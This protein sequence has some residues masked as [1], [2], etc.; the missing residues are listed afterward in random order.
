MPPPYPACAWLLQDLNSRLQDASRKGAVRYNQLLKDF[1]H[2]DGFYP[3]PVVK[4]PKRQQRS[5]QS[6]QD[7][8]QPA[9]TWFK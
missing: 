9:G 4:L 8:M 1:Q 6:Q 7:Q 5:G 2:V 3:K